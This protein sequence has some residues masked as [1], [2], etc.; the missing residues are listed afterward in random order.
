MKI[1][2]RHFDLLP[3]LIVGAG[4]D[5]WRQMRRPTDIK[6]DQLQREHKNTMLVPINKTNRVEAR[7]LMQQGAQKRVPAK[8]STRRI[9]GYLIATQNIKIRAKSTSIALSWGHH[10]AATTPLWWAGSPD[11]PTFSRRWTGRWLWRRSQI[12]LTGWSV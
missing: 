3:S 8:S 12:S 2:S 6:S 4:G 5:D 9:W 7:I 11:D 10:S 1:L